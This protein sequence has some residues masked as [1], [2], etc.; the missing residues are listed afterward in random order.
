MSIYISFTNDEPKKSSH[1]HSKQIP[2]PLQIIRIQQRNPLPNQRRPN[3]ISQAYRP[4][5]RAPIP[6]T[7]SSFSRN[8]DLLPKH[9]H[10][11]AVKWDIIL[12]VTHSNGAKSSTKI[13]RRNRRYRVRD[14][15]ILKAR[16][17]AVEKVVAV[18]GGHDVVELGVAGENHG[19]GAGD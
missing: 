13:C 5:G 12:P 1:P 14:F 17:G 2:N 7:N 16:Q 9:F 10:L 8:P 19:D 3:L 6:G 15:C 11:R 18:A 4:L